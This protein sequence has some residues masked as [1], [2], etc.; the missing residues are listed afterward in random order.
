MAQLFI[1]TT[2]GTQLGDPVPFFGETAV[3]ELD[4]RSLE[5]GGCEKG[6]EMELALVFGLED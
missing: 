1:A 2:L 4:G 5:G 3:N 6:L